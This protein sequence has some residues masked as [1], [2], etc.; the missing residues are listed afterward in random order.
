[1]F[2]F[3]NWIQSMKKNIVLIA[4]IVTAFCSLAFDVMDNNG[5]AGATGSP[6]ESAC[7]KTGCHAGN[8]LNAAGGSITIT[9]STLTNWEYTPGQ[10][11]SITVTVARAGVNL[12][13]FGFEALTTAGANA[14]NL[15]ISNA[16]QTQLKSATILGNS[17]KSVVH[18]LNGGAS[19]DFHTFTFNWTAPATDIGPIT[20]YTAGNA[21][22]GNNLITGDF[23]YTTSQVVNPIP[24][25]IYDHSQAI[26]LSVF[27]NPVNE[28]I[29]FTYKLKNDARVSAKLFSLTGQMLATFFEEDQKAGEQVQRVNLS[30]SISSGVYLLSI[31]ADGKITHKKVYVK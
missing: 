4:G 9:A 13:G 26:N 6:G 8:T 31:E 27:P 22:N 30:P 1:M 17:R 7:N 11:Y 21:A 16:A 23:I 3:Q 29:H 14:G 25:G 15:T 24:A 2:D 20:F 5:K 28:Q 19:A 12:F 18:Q 10:T